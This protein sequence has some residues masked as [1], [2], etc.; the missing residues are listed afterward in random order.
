VKE[1]Y[2]LEGEKV[3]KEEIESRRLKLEDE[4]IH[5]V[6]I[7]NQARRVTGKKLKE[8]KKL[9]DDDVKK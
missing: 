7:G 2:F 3:T 8:L 5:N 9:L 4:R 6:Y 1:G